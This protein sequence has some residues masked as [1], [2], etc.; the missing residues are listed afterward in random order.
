MRLTCASSSSTCAKSVLYVRSATTCGVM[1]HF[2]SRPKLPSRALRTAGVAVVLVSIE[3]SAYGLTSMLRPPFGVWIPVM[4]AALDTLVNPRRPHARG[5][6]LRNDVS[7][8]QRTM[9]RIFTPH[10]SAPLA[11]RM[12]RNGILIST[13]QPPSKSCAFEVQRA[14]QL[15]LGCSLVA[16]KSC[17]PPMRFV[18]KAK[19]FRRSLNVSKMTARWSFWYMFGAS[20]R[21][22]LMTRR[23]G[24]LS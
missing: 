23:D 10:V 8:F 17:S 2:A 7:F 24:S 3:P 18:E 9:R 21:M 14:F 6:P 1:P 19:P 5:T 4:T 22:S 12:E 16:E 13:V 11:K 15:V 20:R